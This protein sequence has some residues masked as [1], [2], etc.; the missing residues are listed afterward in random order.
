MSTRPLLG[1]PTWMKLPRRGKPVVVLLHGGMSSSASLLASIGPGLSKD[2]RIG[3]FDRRG[4]G[5]TADTP[6]PFSY[7]AMADET[8]AYLELLGR[9][10]HLVGHSDGAN[11]A[12]LVALRRPDLVKRVVVVGGNFHYSGLVDF[13]LL[14]AD[15]PGFDEWAQK[16][17]A[18]APEG[19]S[20]A[21]EVLAKTNEMFRTGPTMTTEDLARIT[22]PVLVLAG[23]DD[24]ATLE[25]TVAMYESIPNSQLA[26]VPGTSHAVLKERTKDC[27]RLIRRFLTQRLPP[28]TRAPLRRAPDQGFPG[29]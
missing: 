6:E 24:V 26:I 23:D 2:F 1:H 29:D 9:R 10:A 20:H 15:T 5:R 13:P 11:V 8:I 25:H 12:L 7:E 22:V 16:Y 4:H 21:R 28:Q 19:L 14:E 18:V 17:A 3:A 27:V